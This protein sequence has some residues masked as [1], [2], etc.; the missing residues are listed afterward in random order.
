MNLEVALLFCMHI[1]WLY[2]M[3]KIGLNLI[4]SKNYKDVYYNN[5]KQNN[6]KNS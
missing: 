4:I 3:V 2:Y 5:V 1:F 6:K